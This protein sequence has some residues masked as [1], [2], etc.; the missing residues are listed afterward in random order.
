VSLHELLTSVLD[1]SKSRSAALP[2]RPLDE[3]D[4]GTLSRSGRNGEGTSL[5]T[6]VGQ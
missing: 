2:S 4:D 1:V 3:M 5:S 6:A